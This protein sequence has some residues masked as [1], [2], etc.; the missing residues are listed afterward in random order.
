VAEKLKQLKCDGR[1][2]KNR[3]IKPVV[4]PIT[5]EHSKK[6]ALLAYQMFL[7]P[8]MEKMIANTIKGGDKN[9]S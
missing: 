3:V 2:N 1:N 5:N 4:V 6:R 7:R 9:D 8:I